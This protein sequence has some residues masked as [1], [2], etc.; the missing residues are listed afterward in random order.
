MQTRGHTLRTGQILIIRDAIPDDASS[1]LTFVE[2]A[3][4]ESDNLSFGP[5]E[6]GYTEAQERAFLQRAEAA[7]N[8]LVLLAFIDDAF[9][10]LLTF[11]GGERPRLRHAGE[12]GLTVPKAHWGKG[13]GSLLLDTAIQW[14]ELSGVVTKLNLRVRTDRA[15]A[16]AL[17]KKKGF[18]IE[19]TISRSVFVRGEYF[20]HHWMGRTV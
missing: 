15:S 19:G 3:S 10:G 5:G 18:A 12:L 13:I 8:H 9:V 14:A 11:V 20:D 1:M 17:Y 2:A 4:G 6:F 7:P 16:I